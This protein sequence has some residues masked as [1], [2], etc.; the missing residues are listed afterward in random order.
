MLEPDV[1]AAGDLNVPFEVLHSTIVAPSAR[2]RTLPIGTATGS[3]AKARPVAELD[4]VSR[5]KRQGGRDRRV[6]VKDMTLTPSRRRRLCRCR[7]SLSGFE[8]CCHR[9]GRRFNTAART[10][11]SN[12]HKHACSH[13]GRHLH[14]VESS[15]Q[16][17]VPLLVTLARNRQYALPHARSDVTIDGPFPLR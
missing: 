4:R 7:H 6:P 5:T 10:C 17:R 9:A 8:R 13:W 16:L 11:R 2:R 3:E 1:A 14:S 12:Q 15:D